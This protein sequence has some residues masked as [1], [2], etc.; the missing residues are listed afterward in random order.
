[1][2]TVISEGTIA[3]VR[4]PVYHAR[5][6]HIDIKYHYVRE[7]LTNGVIDLVYCPTQ[8]MTADILT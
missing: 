1:M 3:I 6:K 7:A 5:T 8:Q 4:D 2:P